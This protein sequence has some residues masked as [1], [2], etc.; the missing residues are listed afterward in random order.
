MWTRHL[1][2]CNSIHNLENSTASQETLGKSVDSGHVIVQ[3]SET[4]RLN[5][6]H[7]ALNIFFLLS[8]V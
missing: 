6:C 2:K 3:D 4:Y 8:Y 5:G 7:L 1:E